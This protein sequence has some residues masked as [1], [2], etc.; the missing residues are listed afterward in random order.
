MT[1]ACVRPTQFSVILNLSSVYTPDLFVRSYLKS[2][3]YGTNADLNL[4][5]LPTEFCIVN[6]AIKFGTYYAP[7][8]KHGSLKS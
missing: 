7:L 4:I 1:L 2:I 3:A 5:T 6:A 8:K